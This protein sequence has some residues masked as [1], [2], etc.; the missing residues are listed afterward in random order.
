MSL[1]N[2]KRLSQET[3]H[4]MDE[5]EDGKDDIDDAKLYFVGSNKEK[6]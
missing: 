4:L 2:L 3:K 6:F 5:I 1:I